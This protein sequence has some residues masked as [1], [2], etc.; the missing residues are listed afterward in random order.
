MAWPCFAGIWRRRERGRAR[1]GNEAPFPLPPASEPY[2]QAYA[3]P[4]GFCPA[5]SELYGETWEFGDPE[6][7][8]RALRERYRLAA[9][10]SALEDRLGVRDPDFSGDAAAPNT[11]FA[12]GCWAA[13]VGTLARKCGWSSPPAPAQEAPLQAPAQEGGM[14]TGFETSFKIVFFEV[15]SIDLTSTT[16]AN[17]AAAGIDSSKVVIEEVSCEV[18]LS[19]KFDV[20]MTDA[21]LLTAIDSFCS[22]IRA[23]FQEDFEDVYVEF[24]VESA[25]FAPTLRHRVRFEYPLRACSSVVVVAFTSACAVK[26]NEAFGAVFQAPEVVF[27]VNIKLISTTS[28]A[29]EVPSAADLA[30]K[31]SEFLGVSVE[32]AIDA[33]SVKTQVDGD[34]FEPEALH[35]PRAKLGHLERLAHMAESGVGAFD[36]NRL[37]FGRP[38]EVFTR[39]TDVQPFGLSLEHGKEPLALAAARGARAEGLPLPGPALQSARGEEGGGAGVA[40]AAERGACAGPRGGAARRAAAPRVG[41]LAPYRAQMRRRLPSSRAPFR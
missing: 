3:R 19:V 17:A 24:V 18:S 27:A 7:A 30:T 34:L 23:K 32:A 6:S 35:I 29:V 5:L 28:T 11:A 21:Q 39:R 25:G 10:Q 37:P 1:C 14:T 15:A 8:L 33:N 38:C 2:F 40:V 9:H 31:M 26:L 36:A 16:V 4:L 20:A 41:F 13:L 12:G 22:C